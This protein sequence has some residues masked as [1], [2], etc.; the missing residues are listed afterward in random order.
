MPLNVQ[1]RAKLAINVVSRGT[2]RTPRLGLTPTRGTDITPRLVTAKPII[3]DT[4]K[5]P[6]PVAKRKSEPF[7]PQNLFYSLRPTSLDNS[8][9]TDYVENTNL[10]SGRI[11]DRPNV[12]SRIE[13]GSSQKENV[14]HASSRMKSGASQKFPGSDIPSPLSCRYASDESKKNARAELAV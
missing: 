7:G 5:T 6:L 14:S 2:Y 1:T 9:Y 13:R 10:F 12:F 11:V 4:V 3:F 8:N